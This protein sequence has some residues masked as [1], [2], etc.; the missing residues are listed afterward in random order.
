[1]ATGGPGRW[2]GAAAGASS[3]CSLKAPSSSGLL[4]ALVLVR[5]RLG[6]D[7]CRPTDLAF[8]GVLVATGGPGR[9][10]GA[11]AGASSS[12]SSKAPPSS[13]LLPAPR[14]GGDCCR[15]TDLAFRGVLLATGGPGWW[16][17]AAAGASSSCSSNAPCSS[18]LLT[19]LILVRA[20]LGCDCCRPPDLAFRGVL[21]A[22]GGPG[23]S[24][25]ISNAPASS[26]LLTSTGDDDHRCGEAA[27]A[28]S[29]P[30]SPPHWGNSS[31]CMAHGGRRCTDWGTLCARW[32]GN[33]SEQ[34]VWHSGWAS[35]G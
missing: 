35:H 11:A 27:G 2:C 29:R 28:A 7:C 21:V 20:H 31:S 25:C 6:C 16:R 15:P 9:R 1:M 5:V 19:A 22:T 8:R 23:S 18:G 14:L 26:G 33:A 12:C 24:S 34:E 30:T 3:S 13:G 32:L 4:T 10:H 17:G